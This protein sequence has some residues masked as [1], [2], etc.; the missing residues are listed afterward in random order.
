[1]SFF[2]LCTAATQG[3]KGDAW[4]TRFPPPPGPLKTQ[5]SGLRTFYLQPIPL[6][7]SPLAQGP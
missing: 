1:M 3:E 7:L 2:F 5:Y 6:A 4:Q